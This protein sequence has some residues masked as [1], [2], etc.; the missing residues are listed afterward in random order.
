MLQEVLR[1]SYFKAEEFVFGDAP[2]FNSFSWEKNELINAL[3]L[4]LT[5]DTVVTVSSLQKII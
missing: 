2:G 1:Q 5:W 4:P 3:P